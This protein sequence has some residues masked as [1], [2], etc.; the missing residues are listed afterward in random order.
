M[1]K[2]HLSDDDGDKDSCLN[3]GDIMAVSGVDT[4]FESFSW[5]TVI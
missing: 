2:I 4:A 1:Q 5:D 3:E